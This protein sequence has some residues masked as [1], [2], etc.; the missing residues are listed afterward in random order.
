LAWPRPIVSLSAAGFV[1]STLGALLISINVGLFGF[2]ESLGA[3][4][5]VLS[6]VLEA[7]AFVGAIGWML[8]VRAGLRPPSPASTASE[9]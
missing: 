6:I 1:A 8:L 9:L 3:S 4:F 2:K 5:V 7:I